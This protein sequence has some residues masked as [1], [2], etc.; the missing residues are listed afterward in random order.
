MNYDIIYNNSVKTMSDLQNIFNSV[1][2]K[3]GINWCFYTFA[4]FDVNNS[5][6]KYKQ[7]NDADLLE[8]YKEKHLIII[9]F[10]K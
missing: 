8:N 7:L 6:K 3:L 2:L 5:S 9:D 10:T 1:N 4:I